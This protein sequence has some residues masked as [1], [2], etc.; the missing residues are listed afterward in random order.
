MQRRGTSTVVI[1]KDGT[2]TFW[3]TMMRRLRRF[4]PECISEID[5][6]KL[7]RN[8]YDRLRNKFG[9]TK[10]ETGWRLS[11]KAEQK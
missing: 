2:V 1:H 5:L 11:S 10:S 7:S 8:D 6:R 4:P 3:S 9:L